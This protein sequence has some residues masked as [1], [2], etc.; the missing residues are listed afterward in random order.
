MITI[1]ISLNKKIL[2]GVE[3]IQKKIGSGSV[4]AIRTAERMLTAD[5]T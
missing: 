1:N 3:R 5:E 4:R 2:E